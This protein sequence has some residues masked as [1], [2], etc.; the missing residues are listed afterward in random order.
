[1]SL[2]GLRRRS[3]PVAVLAFAAFF[4]NMFPRI[5]QADPEPAEATPEQ[6]EA[7]RPADVHTVDPPPA[8]RPSIASRASSPTPEVSTDV[9]NKTGVS[10]QAILPAPGSR[11]GPGHGRE[12]LHA[13]LD[14]RG[15]SN[16]SLRPTQR[17]WRQPLA[18]AGL[19]D[20]RRPRRRRRGLGPPPPVHRAP[21]RPRHSGLQRS[22]RRR[23]LVTDAGP[24]RIQWRAGARPHLHRQRRC[25]HRRP[26]RRDDADVG[27]RLAI[28][29]RARRGSVHALLLV[30]RLSDMAGAVEVRRVDGAWRAAR[31]LGRH[32]RDRGGPF[33]REPHLPLG[34]CA[35]IRRRGRRE[36]F[37]PRAREP[38]R[39]SPPA[40]RR[41]HFV[42]H[43]H[44]RHSPRREPHER[45]SRR[46]RPPYAPQL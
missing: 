17:A 36:R 19:R 26:V 28:L 41:R 35:A 32:L 45:A 24:L 43:G 21:D 13:A 1:M 3:A 10:S 9:S 8:P 29:P 33:Q 12:L 37:T 27:R 46:V 30:A 34:H 25:V 23:R 11:Q 39:L 15:Q 14:R 44:L 31:R 6:R 22:T 5:A 18:L 2:R 42:P 38:R 16:R 40:H 20:L 7:E 4:A